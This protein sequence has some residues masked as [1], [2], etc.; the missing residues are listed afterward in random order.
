LKGSSQGKKVS[1]TLFQ[2]KLGMLVYA[3]FSQLGGNHKWNSSSPGRP[4]NKHKILLEKY[5]GVVGRD[6]L[7]DRA[8]A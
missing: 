3:C 1:K 8:S 2:P 7:S 6:D 4:R 5:L